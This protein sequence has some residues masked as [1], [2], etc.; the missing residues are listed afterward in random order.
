MIPDTHIIDWNIDPDQNAPTDGTYVGT[1]MP[2]QL[3]NIKSI[4]KE[5]YGDRWVVF[6]LVPKYID[7]THVEF[8]DDGTI[9][10]FPIPVQ[11]GWA[12]R[13]HSD[14]G[15]VSY[16]YAVAVT[17]GPPTNV[18][19]KMTQGILFG[20]PGTPGLVQMDIGM[21]PEARAYHEQG[22]HGTFTISW[23]AVS[24]TVTFASIALPPMPR[25]K[26]H[27]IVTATAVTGTPPY[28]ALFPQD[29][30][31]SVA[32]FQADLQ[33]APGAGNSVTFDWSIVFPFQGAN[34]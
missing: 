2:R 16:G 30:L 1:D 15:A 23:T 27:V 31:P 9:Y 12:I 33:A 20:A 26:Y 13:F 6:P 21:V 32:S 34:L 24:A 5:Q 7:A 11:P 29:I 22:R 8:A 25:A 19:V 3:R 28:N 14:A 17:V 4:T 10:G 18:Q